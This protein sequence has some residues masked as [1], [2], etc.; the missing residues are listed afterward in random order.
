MIGLLRMVHSV[1]KI[2]LPVGLV[3]L[4]VATLGRVSQLLT[5]LS[6]MISTVAVTLAFDGKL[7]KAAF[8]LLIPAVSIYMTKVLYDS[9]TQDDTIRNEFIVSCFVS[10]FAIALV[11]PKLVD[12]LN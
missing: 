4:T 11:L 2:A 7:L 8:H 5:M 6:V 10:I 1:G 3:Y 9:R 12:F